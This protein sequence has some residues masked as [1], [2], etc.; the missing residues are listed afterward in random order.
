MKNIFIDN[1]P[2]IDLHGE[3]G[4]SA[5]VLV[6]DFIDDSVVLN[7]KKILIVHGRGTGVLRRRVHE[8]LKTDK[9][10]LNYY[11]DYFNDGC[12]IVEIK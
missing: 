1:L 10:I 8:Y 5:I 12:T 3:D 9:R 11:I 6:K 4:D 7:N 2:R